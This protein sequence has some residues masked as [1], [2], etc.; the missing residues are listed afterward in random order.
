M[1]A[2]PKGL[3][4]GMHACCWLPRQ[5]HVTMLVQVWCRACVPKSGDGLGVLETG[6]LQNS[7]QIVVS[8]NMLSLLQIYITLGPK[9]KPVPE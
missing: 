4:Q 9:N 3:G 1:A 7:E 5:Q 6:K 8:I 2:L